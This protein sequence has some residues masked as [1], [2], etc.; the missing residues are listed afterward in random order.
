MLKNAETYEI[1]RPED[2]GLIRSNLVMGKH[3]GRHA[4]K[5]KLE[6]LG[7]ELGEN[8][9]NDAF[10]RFKALADK[11][12]EIFDEDLVA[13]V[14][15]GIQAVRSAGQV[16]QP[17]R[18]SAARA[19]RAHR[20]ARARGRR[21]A[22]ARPW[23]RATGRSTPP[24]TPSARS[25]RTRRRLPLFQI[26]AVTEG[27]DAQAEVTVRLEEN[28]K[29]VNG[30]AADTDTL[31]ASAR[32][33]VVGAQQA[34]DQAREARARCPVGLSACGRGRSLRP[35]IVSASDMP[36][37]GWP[38]AAPPSRDVCPIV[39][40]NGPPQMFSR[41]FGLFSA[42]MAID[43][44][45]ANTLVYVKG[46]GIVLNEPSVVAIATNR[47]RQAGPRGRRRGQADGRPHARQHRGDP[48]LARRRDRRLRGR[49]GDDQA[50]HPPGAS[51]ARLRQPAR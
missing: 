9:L 12:K 23:P 50:L 22:H 21:R 37:A 1:M 38:T 3:S 14:D 32:A 40:W 31:V 11:K 48:A 34:A 47:G 2:V 4:F 7:Y 24:S 35:R 27:T 46:R 43:L 15:D 18:R 51:A 36:P 8:A 26:H 41:L 19:R 10:I 17:L 13:L 49:R 20:R 29:T 42:D 5:K 30:Q 6:E 39:A 44:G 28:G 33:Y 45:T 25:T 16:R